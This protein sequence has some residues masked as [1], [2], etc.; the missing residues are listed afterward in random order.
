[1]TVLVG[2]Q[3]VVFSHAQAHFV[4]CVNSQMVPLLSIRESVL[5]L[6]YITLSGVHVEQHFSETAHGKGIC[7]GHN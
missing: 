5:V 1:M 3:V 2:N 7:D 4:R 6:T